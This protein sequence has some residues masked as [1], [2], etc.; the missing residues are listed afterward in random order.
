MRV[1][2][3]GRVR[4]RV[5]DRVSQEHCVRPVRVLESGLGSG[6]ESVLESVKNVVCD[7][8]AC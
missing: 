5:S 6:L 8:Y 7:R 2:V 1:R 3:R 4:V